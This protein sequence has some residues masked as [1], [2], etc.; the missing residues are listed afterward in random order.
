VVA[1]AAQ[2]YGKTA[3]VFNFVPPKNQDWCY[4]A[5]WV[6]M[7]DP[8]VAASSLR[9]AGGRPA[10]AA[11]RFRAWTDDYSSLFSVLR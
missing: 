10:R 6:L 2:A 4:P 1:A 11:P 7:M 9:F 3:L 5:T 8:A